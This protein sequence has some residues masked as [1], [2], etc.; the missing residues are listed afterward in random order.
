MEGEYIYDTDLNNFGQG[1]TEE[2]QEVAQDQG[3]QIEADV[4]AATEAAVAGIAEHQEIQEMVAVD[5]T[6]EEVAASDAGEML[7]AAVDEIISGDQI[8]IISAPAHIGQTDVEISSEDQLK[9]AERLDRSSPDLWPQNLPTAAQHIIAKNSLKSGETEQPLGIWAQ[10]LDPEDINLL[11]Q[12]G[13]LTS[14]SL[15]EEVKKLQNIAYQLGLEEAKE[16]TRGKL[17]HVLD[18]SD[19]NASD[20]E[21]TR[22][23]Q[24]LWK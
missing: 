11:H 21:K 13:S 17:L 18:E 16:M 22:Y 5:E 15:V 1:T 8:P 19:L 10:G 12:F 4:D 14:S 2:V 3:G 6:M 23:V 7:A 9:S 20:R 24:S